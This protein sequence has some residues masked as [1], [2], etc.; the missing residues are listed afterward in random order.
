MSYL[1]HKT[2]NF[3]KEELDYENYVFNGDEDHPNESKRNQ[4]KKLCQFARS[5]STQMRDVKFAHKDANSLFVFMEGEYM[6]M[7]WI[8]YGDF[9]K[10][11][12]PD[13]YSYVVY[14]RHI[15]NKKYDSYI[16][17][18]FYMAQSINESTAIKNCKRYLR[19]Y[20][21]VEMADIQ[22]RDVKQ[23]AIQPVSQI[24]DKARNA[25]DNV[26]QFS[27]YRPENSNMF[28]AMRHILNSG[29]ELPDKTFQ[30]ELVKAYEKYDNYL[31]HKTKPVKML[32][33]KVYE[34]LGKRTFDVIDLGTVATGKDEDTSLHYHTLKDKDVVKYDDDT[35]S[36]YIVGKISVLSMVDPDTY[37]DDVGFRSKIENTFYVVRDDE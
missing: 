28:K 37:V 25:L 36:E 8:G 27:R 22:L 26:F 31:M 20:N 32:Y 7:G 19:N 34:R 12:T 9:L 3:T 15:I 30:D 14:S 24:D 29:I 21:T 18:Q 5:L 6:C 13:N 10:Y 1:N 11:S 35:L 17:E 4:R 33:V 16:S 2:V 23:H